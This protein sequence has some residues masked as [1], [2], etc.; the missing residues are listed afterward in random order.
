[1]KFDKCKFGILCR[2]K[3][4]KIRAIPRATMKEITLILT[5]IY[6][7]LAVWCEL[8]SSIHPADTNIQFNFT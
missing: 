5:N 3:L 2:C 8:Q 7:F 1:M 6:E 4:W